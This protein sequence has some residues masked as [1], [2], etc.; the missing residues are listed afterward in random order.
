MTNLH[1]KVVVVTEAA[2]GQGVAQAAA[3]A[4]ASWTWIGFWPSTSPVPCSASRPSY[5]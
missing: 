1:G 5:R 2:Q 3:C 4:A